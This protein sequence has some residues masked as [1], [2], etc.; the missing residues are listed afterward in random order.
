MHLIGGASIEAVNSVGDIGRH[1]LEGT[2]HEL[3]FTKQRCSCRIKEL[4]PAPKRGMV[5]KARQAVKS[6]FG[7]FEF[8]PRRHELR[9][10]GIRIK[11]A[12]SQL[13]LLT[14]FLERDGELVTREQISAR[15]WADTRNIDVSTGINTAI[16]RLRRHL[17]EGPEAP[18]AIETLIGLGYRFI[19]EIAVESA[20]E[21]AADDADA[22]V[23]SA[24]GAEV[25]APQFNAKPVMLQSLDEKAV[26]EATLHDSLPSIEDTL[27]EPSPAL[28]PDTAA[29]ASGPLV[30]DEEPNTYLEA[31][32]AQVRLPV[33]Q[34][35]GTRQR[36]ILRASWIV[37]LAACIILL[38]MADAP[39]RSH[40]WAYRSRAVSGASISGAHATAD[41]QFVRVTSERPVGE[42]SAAAVSPDGNIVAYSDRFGVSVH[43]FGSRVD[44]L[45]GVRPAFVVDR[46]AWL[47]DQSGLLMSGTDTDAHIQQVWAV[48]LQGAY[49][50]P[51]LQ[52]A[53]RAVL[54]PDGKRMAFTRNQDQE[55]WEAS[56]DGQ[57]ASRVAKA[58]SGNTFDLLLWNSAGDHL[59][60][61][62][63]AKPVS[64]DGSAEALYSTTYL[65]VD[66]S[67][68]RV[69]DLEGGVPAQ[70]G[71]IL[72][73]GRLFFIQNN[74]PGPTTGTADLMVVQTDGETGRLMGVP[75]FVQKLA[76]R[77]AQSLT[78]SLTGARFAAVFDKVETDTFVAALHWPG[79]FLDEPVQL[80]KGTKQNYPHAWSADG[81]SVL[82]ENDSLSTGTGTHWAVFTVSDSGSP[83]NLVA[84]LP[85]SAAMAQ[86][87][88]DGRW[89]LFLQFEGSPQRATGIFRVPVEGGPAERVPTTGNL[90]E[91]HCS[92]SF[93]GRCVLREAVEQDKLVYYVLDPVK[94]MGEE[95]ARTPWEPNRLGDW[96]LSSD[97]G[98]VA[99]AQHDTLRPGVEIISL[100]AHGTSI[101]ELPVQGH[102]TTLG[103]N[104]SEDGKTLFVECRTKA[105]FELV[106]LD[107]AGHVRLLRKSP[108]LIWA[109]IS[110][111][112]KKIAFP[113]LYQ[114]SSVWVSD[115]QSTS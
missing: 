72:P 6:T 7:S 105:G 22:D 85:S 81:R 49:L 104:W 11:L 23:Y 14:L 45:L 99:T 10:N 21:V 44:R 70:S 103:A 1:A 91:F 55:V 4:G 60:L 80:T 77:H 26:A 52:N 32:Q 24:T 25:D 79:P 78:A 87:S 102:G 86:L 18:S 37:G 82:L 63:A 33:N 62:E 89:I 42:T 30:A 40:W 73:N 9:R 8:D 15:L 66:A 3:E 34:S 114:S 94:G 106:S 95:L 19:P 20:E 74:T 31:G 101:R 46:L 59:I 108:T 83:P 97:G 109:V 58:E 113:G 75:R 84:Q 36:V 43:W 107:L 48:P 5:D 51:I 71:Y 56:S 17:Q 111:D 76:A 100:N 93:T 112:G 64:V 35:P 41:R 50:Q 90:E 98:F 39:I 96:G 69:L 47:P 110:R 13:R 54:S 61:T 53:N 38:F 12:A 29:V 68:G 16:N 92:T 88:P 57:Q 65:C 28:P 115:V 67:S 27:L 2:S